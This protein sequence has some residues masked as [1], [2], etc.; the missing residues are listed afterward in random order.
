MFLVLLAMLTMAVSEW[1]RPM[2]DGLPTGTRRRRSS[3]GANSLLERTV[4]A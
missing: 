2:R 3:D 1:S 4:C